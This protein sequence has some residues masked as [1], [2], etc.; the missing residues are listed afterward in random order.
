MGEDADNWGEYDMTKA[1]KI[2]ERLKERAL[3]MEAPRSDTY[4]ATLNASIF[5][6]IEA[7]SRNL[8]IQ[9]YIVM[10]EE[11]PVATIIIRTTEAMC[12]AYATKFVNDKR[13]MYRKTVRG[14][15]YD[16]HTAALGGL[17]IP[18]TC[19]SWPMQLCSPSNFTL[20]DQGERWD[21]QFLNAGFKVWRTL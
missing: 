8:R 13:V 4:D 20:V 17:V 21:R 16:R 1:T 7:L 10:W 14:T 19:P 3:P 18:K 12:T 6:Q 9:T 2:R 11:V 15:G 5:Q